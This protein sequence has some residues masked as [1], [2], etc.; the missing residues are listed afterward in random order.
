MTPSEAILA[1]V[2]KQIGYVATLRAFLAHTGWRVANN[3]ATWLFSTD[4]AA[5]AA[6]QAFPDA[7]LGELSTLENLE[8]EIANLDPAITLL[9]IDPG[10]PIALD[11]Q[12]EHLDEFRRLARGVGV[13]RAMAEGNYAVIKRF[14]TY[15]VPYFGDLGQEYQVITMPTPHGNMVAAFTA[16]DRVDAF[17]ATGNDSDREKVK[18]VRLSGEQLFSSAGT[19]G[20]G[21]IVNYGSEHPVGFMLDAC[22]SIM[23]S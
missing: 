15:F 12:T 14:E 21:V 18:F 10:A 4:D 8:E 13:E 5:T 6:S 3:Q 20:K 23:E 7:A 22:R 17:L 16:D 2:N 1:G 11:I 9:R 19:L